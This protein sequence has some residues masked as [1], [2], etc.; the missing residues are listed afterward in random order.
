WEEMTSRN[1]NLP[2]LQMRSAIDQLR[3]NANYQLLALRSKQAKPSRE[4]ISAARDALHNLSSAVDV[5]PVGDP[6]K[7]TYKDAL[8]QLIRN[9]NQIDPNNKINPDRP[10][11]EEPAATPVP[12]QAQA[13]APG[14]GVSQLAPEKLTALQKLVELSK[15]QESRW[16]P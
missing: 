7:V 6:D 1:A 3:N 13:T 9:Y 10:F 12:T 8:G 11:T 14:G 16:K 15:A 2:I 5:T 4:E